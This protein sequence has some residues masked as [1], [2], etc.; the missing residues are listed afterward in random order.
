MNKSFNEILQFLKFTTEGQQD[1]P[2]NYLPTLDFQTQVGENGLILY[3]HFDKPMAS[4]LTI[5]RGTALAKGTVHSALRQDMC[6]RL[7]NTSELEPPDTFVQVIEN[8]IQKLRNSDHKYSFVKSVILQAITRYQYMVK[9]SKLLPD[10]PKFQ[11]L[12]RSR[13]FNKV[14]RLLVKRIEH[15]TWYSTLDL[16]DPW[17]Q[18]WKTKIRRKGENVKNNI[19]CHRQEKRK[20]I[21]TSTLFVPATV[22]STLFSKVVD[23][24][25]SINTNIEWGIKIIEKS[26]SMLANML[27]KKFPITD[28]CPLGEKCKACKNDAI[29]CTKKGV[30][31]QAVCTM[32]RSVYSEQNEDPDDYTY[33]GETSR[34]FRLRVKEHMDSLINLN[35]KSF[36]VGHWMECHGQNTFPPVFEFKQIS[37]HPDALS[38]QIAEAIWICEKGSLNLRYEF[39]TNDLCRMEPVRSVLQKEEDVTKENLER[40]SLKERISNFSQVMHN[41]RKREEERIKLNSSPVLFLGPSNEG[42]TNCDNIYRYSKKRQGLG[43]DLIK[44]WKKARMDF[45]TPQDPSKN[46][47]FDEDHVSPVNTAEGSFN[48]SKENSLHTEDGT[49][50]AKTNLSN[51]VETLQITPR[52]EDTPETNIRKIL[53]TTRIVEKNLFKYGLLRSYNSEPEDLNNISLNPFRPARNRTLS[54]T[55]LMKNVVLDEWNTVSTFEGD[56]TGGKTPSELLENTQK[57]NHSP[58]EEAILL[59]K[60]YARSNCSSPLLRPRKEML[61]NTVDNSGPRKEMLFNTIE[62][63]SGTFNKST[64]P[65]SKSIAVDNVVEVARELPK[66]VFLVDPDEIHEDQTRNISDSLGTRHVITPRRRLATYSGDIR[67]LR[68]DILTKLKEKAD[69][70]AIEHTAESTRTSRSSSCGPKKLCT[71][72]GRKK[73]NKSSLRISSVPRN[74]K[75]I[76]SFTVRKTTGKPVVNNRKD[77]MSDMDITGKTSS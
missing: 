44:L 26:G 15:M 43:G 33:V 19:Q 27:R 10:D 47:F 41:V 58:E 50:G 51:D 54:L 21:I 8:Y 64:G 4:N 63:S 74:Q 67:D 48:S 11:P 59:G 37:S 65:E 6:R 32:C 62:N 1:F 35:V 73:N 71:P 5:Q 13:Q 39:K 66:P 60:K 25:D 9:R 61:F 2:N 22:D 40:K 72:R 69:G 20:K 31:Y 53:N 18:D 28:G 3:K 12:Y 16:G 42:V 70:N 77:G 52:K 7:L 30:V 24:E 45:S 23:K 46:C 55:E 17:R 36:Q 56:E 34:T 75:L 29:S 76:S 49:G 14:E 38:R 57:R 68:K